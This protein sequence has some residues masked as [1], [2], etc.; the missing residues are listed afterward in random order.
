[1]SSFLFVL[2]RLLSA[3]FV[4]LRVDGAS[5]EVRA[6]TAR[7]VRPRHQPGAPAQFVPTAN[8]RPCVPPHSTL[9]G[10]AKRFQAPFSLHRISRKVIRDPLP[11]RLLLS[12]VRRFARRVPA[13]RAR[14]LPCCRQK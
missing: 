7:F 3:G 4:H 12:R 9:V 2:V 14:A 10:A 6:P 1:A 5:F 8:C 13:E 11:T